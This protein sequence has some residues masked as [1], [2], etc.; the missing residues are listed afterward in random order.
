[1]HEQPCNILQVN[2][3]PKKQPNEWVYYS[4]GVLLLTIP[5][6]PLTGLNSLQEIFQWGSVLYFAASTRLA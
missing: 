4:A 1:M 5:L 2:F 6:L 3:V